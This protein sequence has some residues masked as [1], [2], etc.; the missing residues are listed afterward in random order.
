[1]DKKR[2]G[3]FFTV[4]NPFRLTGFREWYEMIPRKERFLEPFAGANN[5]VRMMDEVFGEK[6]WGSFDIQP[7]DEKVIFRDT[8]AEMPKGYD[9]IVT[10]PPYLARN[11]A[12]RSG[13]KFSEENRYDDLYKFCLDRMLGEY[14]F[15]AAII[16]E[17]FITSGQFRE[18]L[19][20]TISLTRNMF[21]D[22]DCPVCIAMFVDEDVKARYLDEKD[23]YLYQLDEMV[24][25]YS[26]V[27]G[28]FKREILDRMDGAGEIIKFKFNDPEGKIGLWG[29]DNTREES[30]HFGDGEMIPANKIKVSSR[31]I[32]R[33][34]GPVKDVE[35]V[36][37]R[38]NE[39]LVEFRK[40]TRDVFMTAFKGLR[41][42]GKYRR[43]LDYK[44]AN[45][46]LNAAR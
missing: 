18:K 46:I 1:M 44:I 8:L 19:F 30:I 43:R 2:N 11:S 5:L 31:A 36:A 40:N 14:D 45:C 4:G 16:P 27:Y 9:A 37:K 32:T 13:I 29:V 21:M 33:I 42:D 38:A 3:Q 28:Y 20:S 24:G 6:E 39:I 34:S 35:E 7:M 41:A 12:T 25:K 22:T 17:S 15:V 10:N 26:E 23:F